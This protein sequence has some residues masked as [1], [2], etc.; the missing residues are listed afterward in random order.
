MTYKE[1]SGTNQ[2]INTIVCNK[3]F[4]PTFIHYLMSQFSEYWKSFAKFGTV[5]ILS[6]GRFESIAVPVPIDKRTQQEIAQPLSVLDRKVELH[7][8]KSKALTDLY[9]T[10]L[11]QLMTAEIRLN[12]LDFAE[13]G[14]EVDEE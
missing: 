7:I 13:L 1:E 10:L 11:R 3:D 12:D 6:K 2:Q 5:P 14:I 8:H 9:N 4:E